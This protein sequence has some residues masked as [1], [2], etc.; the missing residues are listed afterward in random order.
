[1]ARPTKQ[2]LDYFPLEVNI[3]S[4]LKIRKIMRACGPYSPTILISLLSNIYK[5]Y[6]YFVVWDSDLPFLIADEV[7][8]SEGAVIEVIKKALQVGFFNTDLYEKFK[9][10][11]SRGIQKRFV[12]A[13]ERRKQIEII[14]QY[15]LIDETV[16]NVHIKLVNVNINSINVCNN[17]QRKEKESKEKK[18]KKN[19]VPT[20]VVTPQKNLSKPKYFDI[21]FDIEGIEYKSSEYLANKILEKNPN[22]KVPKSEKEF[23]KWCVHIDYLLRIDKKPIDEFK[24]VLSFAVKD[25]FWSSNILSTAAL[26]KNYDKLYM[27]MSRA[28]DDKKNE[29]VSKFDGREFGE[30][31]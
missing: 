31:F 20:D 25:N 30:T 27:Q 26:R 5:D 10:L 6:G 4:D 13:I 19:I 21:K 1:M 9:I 11:T 22:A 18:S 7:G 28:K 3:F 12:K 15:C 17:E 8:V 24:K 16:V 14:E 23:Y 2:G 29:T